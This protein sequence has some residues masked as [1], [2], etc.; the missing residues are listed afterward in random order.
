MAGHR[1]PSTDHC[2]RRWFCLL[3]E[4]GITDPDLRHDVQQAHAGKPSLRDWT[5]DDYRQAIL[6]MEH[7]LGLHNDPRPHLRTD[8][9]A[10][11]RAPAT[12]A[13]GRWATDAQCR[14]IDDLCD[15]VS[16][17]KGRAEGPVL[18][19]CATILRGQEKALRRRRLT[20][21]PDR[22]PDLWR[23]LT[24]REASDFIHALRR[25]AEVYPLT[26]DT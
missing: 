23:A 22:G 15:R 25:A 12:P 17:R 24:Q 6:S 26:P 4:A 16:W 10:P 9:G 5:A 20:D 2:R 11:C 3:R 18:Y 1:S 13:L 7:A 19:C 21:S 14:L 8:P